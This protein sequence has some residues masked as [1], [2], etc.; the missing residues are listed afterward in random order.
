M[1]KEST[2]NRLINRD[3][4]VYRGNGFVGLNENSSRLW[5]CRGLLVGVSCSGFS[6]PLQTSLCWKSVV[7]YWWRDVMWCDVTWHGDWE[8]REGLKSWKPCGLWCQGRNRTTDTRIFKSC[9]HGSSNTF[10]RIYALFFELMLI[11]MLQVS[12]VFLLKS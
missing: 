8:K 9:D 10:N 3:L 4:V 7:T 11:V 5:G 12:V 6:W 1:P 2:H